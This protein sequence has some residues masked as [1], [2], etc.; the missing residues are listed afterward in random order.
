MAESGT[1]STAVVLTHAEPRQPE[2]VYFAQKARTDYKNNEAYRAASRLRDSVN[3]VGFFGGVAM[4]YSGLHYIGGIQFRPLVLLLVF[5]LVAF[6][7]I[8]W[9]IITNWRFKRTY[10]PRLPAM[11][12]E[13]LRLCCIG[14]P[15]ELTDYGE[16]SDVPFE[17]ALFLGRFAILGRRWSRWLSV[18]V[19]VL[20]CLAVIGIHIELT[21]TWSGTDLYID[22]C[23]ATI[24]METAIGLLW[25]TYLRLVPG[26][27][28]VLGYAPL[29]RKPVFVDKYDLRDAKITADLR[30]SFVNIVSTPG[31]IEFGISLMRE[32]KRFVYMLFLAAMSTFQPAPLPEDE[33]IG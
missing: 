17:P 23:V 16:W 12:P 13:E 1:S 3:T 21:S 31:K 26:R 5:C 25:P 15:E 33:L 14:A 4:I 22:L 28:D 27:L 24:I 7:G 30:H 6:P 19:F 32:R 11:P 10:G 18:G 2:T 9:P 20:A 8:A 29:S